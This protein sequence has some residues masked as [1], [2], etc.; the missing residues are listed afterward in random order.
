MAEVTDYK[1]L[2]IVDNGQ[3]VQM[4]LAED[5]LTEPVSQKQIIMDA[6]AK[7]L[8]PEMKEQVTPLLEAILQGQPTIKVKSYQNTSITITMPKSR[9]ERMG[10]ENRYVTFGDRLRNTVKEKKSGYIATKEGIRW[11]L[12]A[13]G[14][15]AQYIRY[16]NMKIDKHQ[17]QINHVKFLQERFDREVADLQSER[18]EKI[19]P[20]SIFL[21]K[22]DGKSIT[23]VIDQLLLSKRNTKIKLRKL[24]NECALAEKELEQQEI[25]I[26]EVR[27]YVKENQPKM[28]SFDKANEIKALNI[29]KDE[30]HHLS[31]NN[32]VNKLSNAIDIVISSYDSK[33]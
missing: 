23:S 3:I 5:V 19:N 29:I 25:Q 18:L 10:I 32:N 6:V 31:K 27:V 20:D 15:T 16:V 7:K 4:T 9:Y 24:E 8:D 2:Q 21:N 14:N 13:A 30:L 11:A 28:S 12:D 1:I 33:F 17:E 26:E 22:L